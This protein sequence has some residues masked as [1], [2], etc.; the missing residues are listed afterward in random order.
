MTINHPGEHQSR[1]RTGRRR[2]N[3]R[4]VQVPAIF[5]WMTYLGIYR[6]LATSIPVF[7]SIAVSRSIMA[8]TAQ[9]LK[10]L[11]LLEA[12]IEREEMGDDVIEMTISKLLSYELEKLRRRQRQIQEKMTA[13]EAQYN[14]ETPEF[15]RKFKEGKMGDAM[16]FFEW[17]ALADMHQELAAR[18]AEAESISHATPGSRT[19]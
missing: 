11:Q 1:S 5:V 3:P 14:L 19:S 18:L 9:L 13:F 12:L 2:S 7:N 8:M 16:D 15:S 6:G 17:S 4:S 10:K